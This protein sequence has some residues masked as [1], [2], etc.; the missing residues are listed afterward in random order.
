MNGCLSKSPSDGLATPP[1][2]ETQAA[3]AQTYWRLDGTAG[4]EDKAGRQGFEISGQAGQPSCEEHSPGG[5]V[6]SIHPFPNRDWRA[7]HTRLRR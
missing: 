6:A 1:V 3:R 4:P 2:V 5:P 7:P